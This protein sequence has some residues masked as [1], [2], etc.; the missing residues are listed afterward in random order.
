MKK[1]DATVIVVVCVAVI[2]VAFEWKLVIKRAKLIISVLI[3][4][5]WNQRKRWIVNECIIFFNNLK[6]INMDKNGLDIVSDLRTEQQKINCIFLLQF[7]CPCCQVHA[8]HSGDKGWVMLFWKNHSSSCYNCDQW[9]VRKMRGWTGRRSRT[10]KGGSWG[11]LW[12][13]VM[14]DC[15]PGWQLVRSVSQISLLPAWWSFRKKTGL[16]T[17]CIRK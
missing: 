8:F 5:L 2:V 10:S 17:D 14:R 3:K 12:K 7:S 4:V 13:A 16:C 6:H 1:R 9:R 11:E 15:D